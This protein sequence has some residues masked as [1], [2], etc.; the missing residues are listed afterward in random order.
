MPFER[1]AENLRKQVAAA[2]G[3][4]SLCSEVALAKSCGVSRMTARKAVN[5]LIAEGLIERR[6]GI[7]LFVRGNGVVTRRYRLIVGNI[8]W[9]AAMKVASAVRREALAT[10][11]E[12]E[13]RDA[14]G[15]AASFIREIGSL[16]SSG[17]AGAIVVSIHEEHADAAV[18]AVA[19]N[20][21][22]L[23]LV[24]KDM[25]ADGVGSVVSD[26]RAGGELAAG[27]FFAA[28]HRDLGFIGDFEASTV[29]ARWQGFA[30]ACRKTAG[31]APSKFDIRG[32]DR[33][34]S[35]EGNIREKAARILAFRK[36]P[37]ALFCS[38]DAVARLVMRTFAETGLSVPGDVS[39]VGFD[40]DPIAEWTTPAL[41]TIRQDFDAMGRAAV[42]MLSGRIA[43]PDAAATCGTV[44]VELV[45]RASVAALANL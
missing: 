27:E 28:G 38:C 43:V 25:S 17:A 37:T 5:T 22:P 20:G 39:L 40:D 19:E 33:L 3:G 13:L 30:E 24:D 21:F 32:V 23:V 16:P 12:L 6:A 31:K 29:Q 11:A 2:S 45:R 7:G 26:N 8:L 42:R 36:R 15:D 18:R 4:D 44:P 1:V 35:W 34:G 14:G 9:D 41:T 10:G